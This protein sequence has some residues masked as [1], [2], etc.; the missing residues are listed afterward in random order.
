MNA[1]GM[2]DFDALAKVPAQETQRIEAA[3]TLTR[4]LVEGAD[5]FT[6]KLSRRERR[7]MERA[8][9]LVS[10]DE[11]RR[12]V[13]VLTDEV[14]R[15]SDH[16]AAAQRFKRAADEMG[17][18]RAFPIRDRILLRVGAAAAPLAPRLVMPLVVRNLRRESAG[19][20]I[21]A[22]DSRLR[23]HL[24]AARPGCHANVN[25]LGEAIAGPREAQVRLGRILRTMERSDVN[26][27]SV[28]LSAIVDGI[29][30]LAFDH[31][32]RR[33]AERMRQVYRTARNNNCFVNL[34]MEEY[35]DLDLTIAVFTSVLD[36]LE[37]ANLE[38]GIVL[39]TY[40]PDTVR[41]AEE[42]CTWARNRRARGGSPIK[43]RVVKGANLAMEQVEAEL[44]GWSQAPYA[45]KVEVDAN[46]KRVLDILL[47]PDCADAVRVGLA[48]H[49]VFDIAW[50]M[51]HPIVRSSVL[52]SDST[53]PTAR[54]SFEMLQG[55]A[56]TLA[57][58]VRRRTGTV[59][60]YTPIVGDHDFTS[61]IAYLV[62]RLDENTSP[63]NVLSSL[64]E[65]GK[66]KT[67][68]HRYEEAFR[69]S[70]VLRHSLSTQSRRRQDRTQPVD[71]V[72]LDE[73]FHNE[74]DTDFSLRANRT[75][76]ATLVET[77]SPSQVLP[78]SDDTTTVDNIVATARNARA[79]W[80]S[81]TLRARA[82]VINTIGNVIASRR[83]EILVAMMHEGKKTVSEGDTEVSEAVDFARYYARAASHTGEPGELFSTPMGTIVVAPP[84]NFPY[85][86]AMGGVLA[87]LMAGNTVILKPAPQV[88]AI[89]QLVAQHCWDAGVPLDVLQFVPIPDGKAGRHLICHPDVSGVILT[90]SYATAQMFLEW[91]PSL[92]L[93]AETSGKNAIVI[94]A[95]ADIDLAI[96]DLVR[97]AFGHA[98]QKC[99]AASLAIVQASLYEDSN[100]LDRLTDAVASLKVGPATDLATDIAP[101]VDTPSQ[102]LLRALTM[103]DPGEEWLVQPHLIDGATNLW[104]P[105]VRVGVEPDSWFAR[106]ECFG[107]V[108]GVMRADNLNDAIVMQN[109]GDFG[110]TAGIHSLD[111]VEIHTWCEQV[112]AGNLYVNRTIT[113][114]IV[115]RQPFGGWKRSSVGG[116]AKAGG[117]NYVESLRTPNRE[118]QAQQSGETLRTAF[119]QWWCAN[120]GEQV[121]PTALRAETNLYRLRPF[122]AD[123]IVRVALD[124][125][126]V[127]VETIREAA[128]ATGVNVHWSHAS[129]QSDLQWMECLHQLDSGVRLRVVGTLHDDVLRTAHRVGL[130]VD[131]RPPS[132]VPSVELPRWRLEQS[133]SICRHR[134]GHVSEHS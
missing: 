37:F 9:L 1:I 58:A 72:R 55:M 24:A 103:L 18:A 104:S 128:R 91:R 114:A 106:T 40:L 68:F 117:P 41:A 17:V 53:A 79:G 129:Q 31:T 130:V 47:A 77:A 8:E 20:I 33:A 49:N 65:L 93:F 126:P 118:A 6:M 23:S 122:L 132:C 75:W 64:F 105:G 112:Q 44:R 89:Q 101:L 99:S 15:I 74:P 42:L 69:R 111:P 96:R 5:G 100:F 67:V 133:V 110:L 63:E 86:I 45:T 38:A 57:E 25:V 29:S 2:S 108:L 22:A 97:S 92:A 48:S 56:P 116:T 120:G 109:A 3:I 46:Y 76:A 70:V 51:T 4:A 134:H 90:G 121:D 95:S 123:V 87:A 32:V 119:R 131:L 7:A 107:P 81:R 88:R 62:R 30:A 71:Q 73:P 61:A 80:A 82:E 11:A 13:A 124:A 21:S 78:C 35:R 85:A 54:L 34:D 113:G 98:G 26:Y 36:E 16:R 50:A 19:L 28:K 66:N 43:I 127:S 27:V 125:D 10:S 14:T 84:W 94:T 39:Q 102:D 115:R 52:D 59:L 12:F 60:L 83:A